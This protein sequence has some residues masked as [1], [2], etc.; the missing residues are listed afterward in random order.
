MDVFRVVTR[1]AQS[2]S[3]KDF[4]NLMYKIKPTSRYFV[5]T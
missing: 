2:Q 5:I 1:Q 4:F 3:R